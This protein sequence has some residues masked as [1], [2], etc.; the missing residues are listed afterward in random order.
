[1][2][3]DK[4]KCVVSG[5]YFASAF[6]ISLVITPEKDQI[7]IKY[8]LLGISLLYLITGWYFFSCYYENSSV[9]LRLLTGYLYSSI[10][11]TSFFYGLNWPLSKTLVS[12]TPL[13]AVILLLVN[14]FSLKKMPSLWQKL[15]VASEFVLLVVVIVKLFIGF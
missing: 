6:I 4:I 5:L 14:I 9:L 12:L 7:F 2:K 15:V 1:M 10:F 3:R 8:L 13:W 11:F